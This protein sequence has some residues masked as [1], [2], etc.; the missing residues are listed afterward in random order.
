MPEFVREHG[1]EFAPGQVRHKAHADAQILFGTL[2]EAPVGR[3]KEHAGVRVR[4]DIDRLRHGRADLMHRFLD[5]PEQL[6]SFLLR[7][8][9]GSPGARLLNPKERLNQDA[10]DKECNAPDAGKHHKEEHHQL[11]MLEK[12]RDER[13]QHPPREAAGGNQNDEA[14]EDEKRI[15][16]YEAE[17]APQRGVRAP[18]E[19]WI[20]NRRGAHESLLFNP[21]I[22]RLS[23]G[24][25]RP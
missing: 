5:Q 6:R 1:L 15:K 12:S 22:H 11:E 25:R 19:R 21:L 13:S 2:E 17:N 4:R 20:S 18:L 7:H 8:D 3:V 14:A 23:D 24:I 16:R 9:P 10:A